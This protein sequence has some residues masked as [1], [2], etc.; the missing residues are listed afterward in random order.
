MEE[1][2]ELGIKIAKDTEEEYWAN[3][4]EEVEKAIRN[5]KRDEKTLLAV[6]NLCNQQLR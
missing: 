4:K 3:K 5:N 6:L 1:I 2:K